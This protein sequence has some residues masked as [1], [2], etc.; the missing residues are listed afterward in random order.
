MKNMIQ[1]MQQ[2]FSQEGNKN[3]EQNQLEN[4]ETNTPDSNEKTPA[5][6]TYENYL[7]EAYWA[8]PMMM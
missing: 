8:F 4:K 7:W 3:Y 2:L 1:F 6:E 5:Q